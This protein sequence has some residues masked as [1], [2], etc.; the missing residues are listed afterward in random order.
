MAVK[1]L[2]DGRWIT[3]YRKDGKLKKEYFG[4]GTT[5]EADARARDRELNLKKRRPPSISD[6]GPKFST[7]AMSYMQTKRT[8]N[9]KG[10]AITRLRLESHILP[11]IGHKPAIRLTAK[12]LDLYVDKRL[13]DGLKR[14]T[15]RREL[16]IIKA[17]MSFAANRSPAMIPINPVRDYRKPAADDD[18]IIPPDKQET[19][20]ILK[21]A[22]PHL[23]RAVMLAYYTGLRPGNT[24]L[25]RL[26]WHD[27]YWEPETIL[28]KSAEKG[29]I[30]YRQV[31]LHPECLQMMKIWYKEDGEIPDQSIIHYH[32]KPVQSIKT[33]W[34]GALKRAK[35]T[36]RIRPYDMRHKFI[37]E[38]LER[39]E[40]I[41]AL[42]EIVGSS[43][44]TLTT[45]YQHVSNAMR[46]KTIAGIRPLGIQKYAQNDKPWKKNNN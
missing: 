3:Y 37:T 17:I 21:N 4:R 24:E 38:A 30:S 42:S 22:S 35:I 34:R 20:A 29:G 15:I 18:I 9:K 28:I 40:D 31:P 2:P 5:A 43:P 7:C 33:A 41:K 32:G 6:D 46:R 39:G 25:L 1:Q 10:Y 45:T 19:A 36:R 14:S 12:D 23:V 26:R 8:G 44:K 11:F 13:N 16:T 27:V